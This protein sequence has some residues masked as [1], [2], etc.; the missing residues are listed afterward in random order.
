METNFFG[1]LRLIQ[2]VLPHMR[3]QSS[4]T[5]INVSSVAGFDG[6]PTCG[7]Y[8][9]SKFALEG[10]SESL[11]REVAPFNIRVLIVEPGGFRTN[12]LTGATKTKAGLNV[13]YKGGPAEATLDHFDRLNGTQKGDPDKA[14]ARMFE[15]VI[16][17]AMGE[18]LKL[19]TE[20]MLRLP[21]GRDCLQRFEKKF[22]VLRRNI[23]V[24]RECTLSTDLD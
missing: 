19:G 23:D 14:A 5:I 11:S 9:G 12:F 7:L 21:L 8:A 18:G 17:T 10:L 15:V 24:A 4:G 22:S 2:S 13:A 20:G 6:L 16:G 1:P 3:A